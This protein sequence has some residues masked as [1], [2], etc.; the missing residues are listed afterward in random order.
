MKRFGG[1]RAGLHLVQGGGERTPIIRQSDQEKPDLQVLPSDLPDFLDDLLESVREAHRQIE[2]LL[3]G[4]AGPIGRDQRQKLAV[5]SNSI[6]SAETLVSLIKRKRDPMKTL[7]NDLFDLRFALHDVVEEHIASAR[8]RRVRIDCEISQ[9]EAL[10]SGDRDQMID[11]IGFAFAELLRTTVP[12]N[13]FRATLETGDKECTLRMGV[14]G[15]RSAGWRFHKTGRSLAKLALDSSGGS[16]EIPSDG[17]TVELRIPLNQGQ[18]P[19]DR[20]KSPI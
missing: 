4:E 7:K 15:S 12:G 17:S 14:S 1:N 6:S 10:V 18:L 20:A 8:A 2:S 9:E 3:T 13:I 19:N 5:A 16:L 11:L